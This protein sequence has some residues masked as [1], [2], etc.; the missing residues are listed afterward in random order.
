[1]SVVTFHNAEDPGAHEAFER[2]RREHPTGLF[3]NYGSEFDMM[4]HR[5]DCPHFVFRELRSLT[6]YRKVCAQSINDLEAWAAENS[7]G[8][9]ATCRTCSPRT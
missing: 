4:L 7:G 9:L 8:S 5:P 1:M 6:S 2:W 3:I